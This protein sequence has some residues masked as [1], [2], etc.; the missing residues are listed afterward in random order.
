MDELIEHVKS[1]KLF[2]VKSLHRDDLPMLCA[3]AN[4]ASDCTL[5]IEEAQAMAPQSSENLPEALEDVIYRGRHYNTTLVM[6]AQRASTIHIAAR[7]Q[8]RRLLV[9]GQSEDRDLSWLAGQTRL[10]E[11]EIYALPPLYGYDCRRWKRNVLFSL[12]FRG[13]RV[14]IDPVS[15]HEVP[16]TPEGV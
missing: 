10:D 13:D 11:D 6:V 9:F 8:W 3:V 1:H 2:S 14:I 5:V 7:S 16:S 4:G 12:T 15:S